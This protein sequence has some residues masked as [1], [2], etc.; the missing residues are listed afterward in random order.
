MTE[1]GRLIGVTGADNKIE[2]DQIG[3][4]LQIRPATFRSDERERY[5]GPQVRLISGRETVGRHRFGEVGRRSERGEDDEWA[6]R[7]GPSCRR[8]TMRRGEV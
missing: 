5:R 4:Y 2:R 8:S 7:R 1:K 3:T 6:L